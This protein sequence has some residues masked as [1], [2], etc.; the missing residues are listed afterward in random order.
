MAKW[1]GIVLLLV[2][3][4]LCCNGVVFAQEEE[5][6]TMSEGYTMLKEIIWTLMWSLAYLPIYAGGLIIPMYY[7]Q[8][9]TGV[10]SELLFTIA[11][12]WLGGMGANYVGY[13][14]PGHHRWLI[15]LV[16]AVVILGWCV[17]ICTRSW[18]DLSL[19][20]SLI[21]GVVIMVLCTPYFGPTWRISRP[22]PPEEESRV[23][24][25]LAGARTSRPPV[26]ACRSAGETP[27]LWQ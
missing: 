14:L 11:V 1:S 12:L 20:E 23:Y 26:S 13:A 19:K 3:L 27:A 24:L 16:A 5:M 4:L 21:V 10:D 8:R 17:L 22:K 2:L 9:F 6:R 25:Q 18:A 7:L 15:L